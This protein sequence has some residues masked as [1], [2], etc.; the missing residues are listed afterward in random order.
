ME[1]ACSFV[2]SWESTQLTKDALGRDSITGPNGERFKIYDESEM[3]SSFNQYCEKNGGQTSEEAIIPC[4][5]DEAGKW[6]YDDYYE[7]IYD[8]LPSGVYEQPSAEP[9]IEQPS[10]EEIRRQEEDR[11]RLEEER[12]LNACKQQDKILLGNGECYECG[13]YTY[14]D[15]DYKS[16]TYEIC[17]EKSKLLP[18]GKCE[19][20]ADGKKPDE[21]GKS[22]ILDCPSYTYYSP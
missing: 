21:T 12:K 2:G 10:A 16:C 3:K 18:N 20:C 1:G 9:Q 6:K 19:P 4:E 22:C 7:E 11:K 5:Q 15:T 8:E 13:S 17:D 14:P